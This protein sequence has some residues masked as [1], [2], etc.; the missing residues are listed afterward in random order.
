MQSAEKRGKTG[1]GAVGN[2]RLNTGAVTTAIHN[3]LVCLGCTIYRAWVISGLPP[4]DLSS[5][6]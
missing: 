2:E 3:A 5:C 1:Q 4:S 6:V